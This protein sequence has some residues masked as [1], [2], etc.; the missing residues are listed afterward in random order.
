MAGSLIKLEQVTVSSAV[1]SVTLGDDKWDTSYDVYMVKYSN[2][3]PETDAVNLNVRFT[4]S[5]TADSSSN[6]D[7]AFK[8][9]RAD[10]TFGNVS[11]TNATA[12]GTAAGTITVTA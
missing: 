5:G 3:Q 6:Y 8:E 9:L 7:R 4:V 2:V 10:T 1:A 11:S 12:I